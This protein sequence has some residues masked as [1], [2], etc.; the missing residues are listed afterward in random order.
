MIALVA[1]TPPPSSRKNVYGRPLASCC[2]QP[3]TGFARDGLCR[4]SDQDPGMHVVCAQVTQAFLDF[5][6]SRGND[7]V[8]PRP[9]Y[10]FP[11]LK[12]GSRWCLC[13]SRWL[14]ADDQKVAP[15][16]FLEATDEAALKVIPLA[17]L[18][19]HAADEGNRGPETAGGAAEKNSAP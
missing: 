1:A 18:R 3:V 11:G 9:D 7:L 15:P 4:H 10:G 8:T 2:A 13:A 17:R 6:R 19:A 12:P 16:V 5:S 14:E